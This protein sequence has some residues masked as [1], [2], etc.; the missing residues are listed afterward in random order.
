[1]KFLTGKIFT[2]RNYHFLIL[3][4]IMASCA[5]AAYVGLKFSSRPYHFCTPDEIP[6]TQVINGKNIPAYVGKLC[7]NYCEGKKQH[8]KDKCKASK[9][10]TDTKIL[11]VQ[12]DFDQFMSIDA[13]VV[14]WDMLD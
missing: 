2:I 13:Q 10:K 4:I 12:A 9:W 5:G 14:P 3:S 8:S 1:M 7:Y 6:G 11:Y